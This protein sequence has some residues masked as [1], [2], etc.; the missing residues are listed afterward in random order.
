MWEMLARDVEGKLA[1]AKNIYKFKY[2]YKYQIRVWRNWQS[3]EL[4]RVGLAAAPGGG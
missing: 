2:K 1:A 4:A 3:L